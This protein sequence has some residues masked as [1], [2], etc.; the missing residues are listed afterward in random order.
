MFGKKIKENLENNETK[1]N[2]SS[3]LIELVNVKKQ[4]G[5]D[6]PEN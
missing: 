3:H 4:Y 6:D 2:S 5:V 1:K